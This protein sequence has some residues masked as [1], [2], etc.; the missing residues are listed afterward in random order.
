MPDHTGF[1][2]NRAGA[3][4]LNQGLTGKAYTPGQFL[5]AQEVKLG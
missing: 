5:G 2:K 1:G 3:V 4:S